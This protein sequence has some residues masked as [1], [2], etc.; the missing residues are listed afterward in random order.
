ML[1]SGGA[2]QVRQGSLNK[3]GLFGEHE[4]PCRAGEPNV[5]GAITMG[6]AAC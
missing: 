1:L 2:K 4:S 5:Y 6:Q 3:H